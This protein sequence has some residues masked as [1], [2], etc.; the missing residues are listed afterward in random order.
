EA[1]A[2]GRL[3]VFDPVLAPDLDPHPDIETAYRAACDRHARVPGGVDA[4]VSAPTHRVAVQVEC[5]VF[6]AD[7]DPVVLA[8]REVAG[9]FRVGR[10]GVAAARRAR[11]RHA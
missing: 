1:G 8:I 6:R 3:D 5:D 4:D 2:M 9:Q 10:D 7:D 11:T